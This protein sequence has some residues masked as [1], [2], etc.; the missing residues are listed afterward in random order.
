M[1]HEE[2]RVQPPL[3]ELKWE[4]Y[5]W[6]GSATL[7]SWRGFRD[8]SGAYGSQATETPSEGRVSVNVEVQHGDESRA[9]AIEQVEAFDFLLSRQYEIRDVILEAVFGLYPT[10]QKEIY[11]CYDEDYLEEVKKFMPDLR[12]I[13]LLRD[14]MGLSTVHLLRTV[15][16]GA[17]YIGFEFGC[18]WEDEHGLGVLTHKQR[19]VDIGGA[20][21]AFIGWN[22][23][24]DMR[25]ED[26][27]APVERPTKTEKPL[28]RVD[29]SQVELPF[30]LS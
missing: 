6:S 21:T 3:P 25:G 5:S 18:S 29:N 28:L 11:E 15:K 23:E 10:W 22:A 4:T 17:S 19:I 8:S 13:S 7:E 16:D 30:D 1:K 2:T 26:I 24:R 14:L 12:E 9:I 20:D 27:H